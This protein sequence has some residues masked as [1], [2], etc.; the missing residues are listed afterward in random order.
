MQHQVDKKAERKTVLIIEDDIDIRTFACRV[1]E[2]EG[3]SCI[4]ADNSDETFRLI[5]EYDV[6]LVL[7]DLRLTDDDGWLILAQLK[8][9]KE[10]SSI[11]VIVF[12]A[13]FG[14]KQRAQALELGAID[15]L[16]KPLSAK[17]LKQAI[18][19]VLSA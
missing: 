17:M 16:V 1:I 19:K 3:H 8:R 13:S 15:Y 11:P 9:S 6:K 2:L 5:N 14:E 7:L 4:Y 12:T 18:A 10:T